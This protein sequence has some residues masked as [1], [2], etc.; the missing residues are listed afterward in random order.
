MGKK[1]FL[2]IVSILILISISMTDVYGFEYGLYDGFYIKYG[3]CELS[4]E[5]EIAILVIMINKLL[6]ELLEES[7][8]NLMESSLF[9]FVEI[10]ESGIETKKFQESQKYTP[11]TFSTSGFSGEQIPVVLP[12]DWEIGDS[13]RYSVGP[14]NFLEYNG[15]K[16]KIIND[17][18]L[19]V[20]EFT[21]VGLIE[22]NES[23]SQFIAVHQ[24]DVKTGFL[25][26]VYYSA[27]VAHLLGIA[28]FELMFEAI[29]ISKPPIQ[30]VV[31]EPPTQTVL[32]SP[33]ANNGGGCLIATATFGSELAP[34]VQQLREIRDNTLLQTE[35]GRSFME[36]F[37]QFYYSFSP[38]IAD[39]ERENPVFKEVVK[40]AITPL[41]SSLSLLNYVD[42]NSEYKV[43]GYGISLILLNVGMYFV[44]PAIVIHR[45]R[46]FV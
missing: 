24:Y 36:S 40:L 29:D 21:G 5:S 31:S 11:V 42:M 15:T 18:K 7:F 8:C 17:Q 14:L 45:V 6:K 2:V 43:L 46:K 20:F 19:D 4:T 26:S 1:K 41:L 25:V 32:S 12:N 37:N 30:T 28:S 22:D 16:Q 39:L 38:E 33:S 3:E 13:L 44:L 9:E 23:I 27:K 10:T 34:Q 35:S